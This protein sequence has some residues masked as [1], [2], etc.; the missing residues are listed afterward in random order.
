MIKD[1]PN[2]LRHRRTNHARSADDLFYRQ[3]VGALNAPSMTNRTYRHG[4]KIVIS[5]NIRCN[6]S[7]PS[8]SWSRNMQSAP[9]VPPIPNNNP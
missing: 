8:G 9:M 2:G 4:S 3:P 7:S 6:A 5:R 1:I